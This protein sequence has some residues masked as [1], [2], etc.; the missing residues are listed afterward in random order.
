V[1]TLCGNE[2][3]FRPELL[4]ALNGDHSNGTR[5]GLGG[6]NHGNLRVPA[7]C[8]DEAL[9]V[10]GD[11]VGVTTSDVVVGIAAEAV[12]RI[13]PS[14][15]AAVVGSGLVVLTVSVRVA[16]TTKT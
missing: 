2:V 9:L 7:V 11:L 5:E 3:S 4:L 10:T 1:F 13:S 12:V 15:S 8:L 14:G 6:P 16:G